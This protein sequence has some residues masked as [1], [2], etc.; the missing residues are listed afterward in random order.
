MIRGQIAIVWGSFHV[1][2]VPK[3]FERVI[4]V[5]GLKVAFSRLA[6]ATLAR[7]KMVGIKSVSF[8]QIAIFLCRMSTT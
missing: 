4:V 2:Q 1:A 5:G 6:S 3:T 8:S 7:L